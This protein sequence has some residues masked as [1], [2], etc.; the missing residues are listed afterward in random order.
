MRLA[1]ICRGC[2]TFGSYGQP[3]RERRS[4][5]GRR[6]DVHAA[7]VGLDDAPHHGEAE[8]AA[9]RLGL[10][11]ATAAEERLE[12]P[13]AFRFVDPRTAIAHPNRDLSRGRFDDDVDAH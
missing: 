12:Q 11:G 4:T 3:D 1:I 10:A 8:T 2:P 5:F 13:L 6:L 9:G 7:A